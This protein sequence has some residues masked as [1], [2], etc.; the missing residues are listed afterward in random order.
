MPL[1]HDEITAISLDV[2]RHYSQP[3]DFVGAMASD[4]VFLGPKIVLPEFALGVI[5]PI[6][7]GVLT[8][9]KSE[10]IGSTVFD[11]YLVLVGLNYVPLLLHAIEFARSGTAER[12]I[13]CWS[14]CGKLT[15]G[16]TIALRTYRDGQLLD[17]RV[18]T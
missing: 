14:Q 6:A 4:L 11:S 12:E 3:L 9:S 18:D 13:D 16:L 15:N 5:G 10:S 8:L 17:L 1:A 2:I 7:L